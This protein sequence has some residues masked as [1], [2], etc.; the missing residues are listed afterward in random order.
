V[1]PD[2]DPQPHADE[3]G[4]LVCPHGDCSDDAC[5]VGAD[6]CN[7]ACP[8][9]GGAVNG[10]DAKRCDQCGGDLYSE[11]GTIIVSSDGVPEEVDG[12]DLSAQALASARAALEL[13]QRQ[14]ALL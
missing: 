2:Y 4:Q 6:V 8:V 3:A 1:T 9:T 11:D 14:L 5:A 12:D 7:G 10:P 13:R